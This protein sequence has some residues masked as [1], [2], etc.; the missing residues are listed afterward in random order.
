MQINKTANATFKLYLLK[1][2]ITNVLET[3]I[4]KRKRTYNRRTNCVSIAHFIK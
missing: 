4:K 2:T 1:N 3:F